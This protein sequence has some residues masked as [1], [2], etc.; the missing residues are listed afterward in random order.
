MH[1]LSKRLIPWMYLSIAILDFPGSVIRCN[2]SLKKESYTFKIHFD[3]TSI[4][5]WILEGAE[6]VTPEEFQF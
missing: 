5:R 3:R 2:S 4:P 1:F 6:N